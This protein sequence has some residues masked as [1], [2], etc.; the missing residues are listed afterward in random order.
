MNSREY[1][2]HPD[3]KVIAVKNVQYWNKVLIFVVNI[4]A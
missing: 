4:L 3:K 2:L 1:N